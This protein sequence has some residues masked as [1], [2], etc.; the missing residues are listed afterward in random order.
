MHATS[1]TMVDWSNS[2]RSGQVT[3]PISTRTSRKKVPRRPPRCIAW[4]R[5]ERA[6]ALPRFC[7]RDV[8]G[9]GLLVVVFAITHLF[10]RNLAGQ[11]GFEPTACG[12]GDRCSS[13][14]SYCPAN[15]S[16]YLVSLW[17][18]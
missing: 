8:L 16:R 3:L 15:D 9:V 6:T 10:R 5:V 12:F 14:L 13:Q 2:S 17:T 7:A 4:E 1:T 11:E 18:V